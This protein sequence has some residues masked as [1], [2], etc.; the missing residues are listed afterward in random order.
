MVFIYVYPFTARVVSR[1]PCL[2]CFDPFL[3]SLSCPVWF[4]VPSLPSPCP[5]PVLFAAVKVYR[6]L[7]AFD[8]NTNSFLI[9]LI[10]SI[11]S[12]CET[13]LYILWTS[14]IRFSRILGNTSSKH[15]TLFFVFFQQLKPCI[16]HAHIP[17][18]YLD[19][20]DSDEKYHC[21]WNK[22]PLE[23]SRVSFPS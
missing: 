2:P 16:W 1:V 14:W 6:A 4:S 11:T 18:L 22:W 12:C 9:T 13:R 15:N 21:G 7:F 3:F 23:W 8:I 5:L 19:R 17:L 10:L 20:S